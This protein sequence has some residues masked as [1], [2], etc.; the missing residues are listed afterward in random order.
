MTRCLFVF[1]DGVGLGPASPHNPLYTLPLPAFRDLAGGQAW[2]AE[3]TPVRQKRHVFT[4]LD[5]TL[6]MEGLPQS[7]TGQVALFAGIDGPK[8]HGRHFGPYPPSTTHEPLAENSVFERLK[9]RGIAPEA[10]ALANGYPERY[11]KLMEARNRWNTSSRAARASGV[12]LRTAA[13]LAIGEALP[14]DF[15]GHAWQRHIDPDHVTV[16]PEAA[17]QRLVALAKRHRF[18]LYDFP[19]TDTA[20]HGRDGLTPEIVLPM[21]DAFLGAIHAAMDTE[22]DLLVVSSDHGNIERPTT[23][24]HTTNPVPLIAVGPGAERFA[25]AASLLDVAPALVEALTA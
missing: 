19:H 13:D 20:G 18:T 22:H 11:F 25:E 21:V 7:G 16:S 10:M 14:A 8:L 4:S 24:S 2:T 1:L 23:K 3:A 6:G 15:T 17:G 5:A 9:R 12:R